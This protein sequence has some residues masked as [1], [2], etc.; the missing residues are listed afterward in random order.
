[1]KNKNRIPLRLIALLLMLATFAL[2]LIHEIK[3][4]NVL[5]IV[6]TAFLAVV[7][8][9]SQFYLGWHFFAECSDGV[10]RNKKT[11]FLMECFALI[12]FLI[13][14][15]DSLESGSMSSLLSTLCGSMSL[16]FIGWDVASS[17][18]DDETFEFSDA[19][20]K[21]NDERDD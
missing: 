21:S 7:Y 18:K 9:L 11:F 6:T 19:D 20:L 8:I 13:L 15:S 5:A 16:A 1:M 3:I 10:I 2:N 17:K 12:F 14:G 4:G